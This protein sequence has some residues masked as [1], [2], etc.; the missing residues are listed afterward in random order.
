MEAEWAGGQWR[1]QRAAGFQAWN[2]IVR[3]VEENPIMLTTH[4]TSTGTV[5]CENVVLM[6]YIG[7]GLWGLV[8]SQ[9][10]ST[11]TD[12]RLFFPAACSCSLVTKSGIGELR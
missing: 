3:S 8:V 11:T 6:L 5:G 4:P 2:A 12:S 10:T 7:I 9:L 1:S